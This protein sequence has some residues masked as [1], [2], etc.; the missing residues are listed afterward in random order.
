[1]RRTE[2]DP[3]LSVQPSVAVRAI[4]RSRAEVRDI[5]D[6]PEWLEIAAGYRQGSV[7]AKVLRALAFVTLAMQSSSAPAQES[8]CR[9]GGQHSHSQFGFDVVGVGD[10]DGD[11][12]E[13]FA[14]AA[15]GQIV[16]GQRRGQVQVFSGGPA[17][18][19]AS[20]LLY[21]LDGP[22]ST[23]TP[24]VSTSFAHSIDGGRDIDGDGVSDI[25][26]GA[27]GS[28]QVFLFSGATGADLMN[29]SAVLHAGPNSGHGAIVRFMDADG[30][31]FPDLLVTRDNTSLTLPGRWE[32]IDGEWLRSAGTVGARTRHSG[33]G[34]AANQ[35]FG[36]T[37]AIIG[38]VDGDGADDFAIGGPGGDSSY[39]GGYVEVRSGATGALLRQLGSPSPVGIG[40]FGAALASAGDLDADGRGDLLVGVPS[41]DGGPGTQDDRGAVEVIRGAF[42]AGASGATRALA[43]HPGSAP[44]ELMGRTVLGVDLNADGALDIVAGFCPTAATGGVR[45]VS[46]RTG[47]VMWEQRTVAQGFGRTRLASLERGHWLVVGDTLADWAGPDHGALELL[48]A[49][50]AGGKLGALGVH[51]PC[52]VDSP[53]TGCPHATGL[54]ASPPHGALLAVESGT[55]SV[56]GAGIG[57]A[58]TLGLPFSVVQLW[59]GNP[60]AAVPVQ[61]GLVGL[62]VG[63]QALMR[64]GISLLGADGSGS[65]GPID[66]GALPEVLVGQPLAFQ[67]L[68][69]DV[70]C[71]LLGT[72]NVTNSY[73]VTMRH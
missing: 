48:R 70:G 56:S 45:A 59:A 37:A 9:L 24:S 5:T 2:I 29:G 39:H 68:Y 1:M 50:D 30:D 18:N 12:R 25:V 61:Y 65:V 40:G 46:G 51:C 71:G 28:G 27:P 43:L 55:A 64:V 22:A 72:L 49:H 60:V 54:H 63:P 20:V 38:D 17:R 73:I 15:P 14:V 41:F 7:V 23:S 57:L 4:Q 6:D 8:L 42:L 69:R 19:G 66:L 16:Q 11:G 10:V 52:G 33:A 13:D 67:G 3:K 34:L 58:V 35:T 36:S 53:S 26:V 44:G 32:V 62:A 47:E 21:T 31:A